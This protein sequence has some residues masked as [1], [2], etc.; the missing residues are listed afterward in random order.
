MRLI[1]RIVALL[2]ICIVVLAGVV[3]VRTFRFTSRQTEAA[4]VAGIAVDEAAVAQRLGEAIRFQTISSQNAADFDGKPF[5][6][7]HEFLARTFPKVYASL[8]HEVVSDYSL[9]FTWKGSDPS[10]KPILLM[11][12]QDVVPVAPDT[13]K[14][15][16]HPAFDGTVADGFIWG[17]GTLDD[18]GSL[19]AILE[20]VESL[21]SEGYQPK[22]TVYLAFGHDE[23]VGGGMG[24]PKISALL[25][26]RGVKL[27]FV[28][29]EGSGIVEGVVPG[30]SRPVGAIAIGEKGYLSLE[31]SVETEGGHS[32]TPPQH[33]AI[34]ILAAA[35]ARLEAHPFPAHLQYT[36]Q[37]F[38][39]VGP[40]MSFPYRMI[41][42]NLWLTGPLVKVLMGANPEVN[43]SIRTT[44]A[45][46]IFKAGFKENVLPSKAEAVVNFRILPGDTVASVT[47]R[48][49]KTI[50]DAR[51]KIKPPHKPTEPS[52][53][54][55]PNAP[56][57]GVLLRTIRET[58]SE[59]NPVLSPFIDLGAT[60]SR[61]YCPICENVY[62]F[63]P[64][65][66][67]AADM[68]R[69]H[70]VNERVSTHVYAGMIKFYA[71]MIKNMNS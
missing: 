38:S 37:F 28:L 7:L 49:K 41:F 57:Y 8:E 60:D 68:K 17:R 44:T 15:W 9:L 29:D 11:A 2:L 62:R 35:I 16:T 1:K 48:V 10:Q 69:M 71:Q 59:Y 58:L 66:L 64:V 52:P 36:A 4:P 45:A 23:E 27:D 54:S 6:A 31:L 50:H 12:H 51:V 42:A 34:G 18:K 22:R 67:D 43:A 56:N 25:E 63:V 46:T 47:E 40:E 5:L 55:D 26:S 24:A 20:S 21:L 32:S 19:M 14:E 65:K 39:Y 70:G 53:V 61:H 13:E 30:V 3:L 33:T